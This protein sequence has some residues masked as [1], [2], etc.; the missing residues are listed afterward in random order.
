[1]RR[2]S[3]HSTSFTF[4]AT[5]ACVLLFASAA[6]ASGRAHLSR[7]LQA[8]IAAHAG[9]MRVLVHG[10][11]DE[12]TAIAS[13]HGVRIVRLLHS[14]AVLEANAAQVESLRGDPLVDHLSSDTVITIA[15]DRADVSNAKPRTTPATSLAAAS[16]APN[17]LGDVI[18]TI[19]ADRL[20]RGSNGKSA[21]PSEIKKAIIVFPF[22]LGLDYRHRMR[23][24]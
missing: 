6:A 2:R 4:S 1:M 15:A 18:Q 23:D 12:V 5:C 20:W 22:H 10:S 9:T 16:T 17:L 13:R 11:V 7:D 19:G 14:G 3:V 8:Q 24:S 21:P